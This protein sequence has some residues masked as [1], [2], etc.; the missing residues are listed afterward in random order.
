MTA[1]P[2]QEHHGVAVRQPGRMPHHVLPQRD[3]RTVRVG[4]LQQVRP[5]GERKERAVLVAG[6][7]DTVGVQQQL[8]LARVDATGYGFGPSLPWVPSPR[9]NA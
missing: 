5:V 6:L 2:Q 4:V 9:G 7:G 3:Q 1:T 8:L